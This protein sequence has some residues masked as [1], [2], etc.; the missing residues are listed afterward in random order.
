MAGP[1]PL[2]FSSDGR[3]WSHDGV[4]WHDVASV[5]PPAEGD[6]SEP[7]MRDAPTKQKH[8]VLYRLHLHDRIGIIGWIVMAVGIG[9]M[10]AIG[11][12]Y[13]AALAVCAAVGLGEGMVRRRRAR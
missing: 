8:R 10:F 6:L 5:P 9:V 4:T 1:A 3:C 13:G 11:A 2:R 12:G 7:A